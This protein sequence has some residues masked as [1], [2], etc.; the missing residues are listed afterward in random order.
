MEL[1]TKRAGIT[2]IYGFGIMGEGFFSSYFFLK[3]CNFSEG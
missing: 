3:L 2:W 1:R